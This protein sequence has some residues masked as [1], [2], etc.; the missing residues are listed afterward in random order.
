[1]FTNNSIITYFLSHR[2]YICS[3]KSLMVF[4]LMASVMFVPQN[5]A[6]AKKLRLSDDELSK[7]AVMPVF[8]EKI[9][10]KNRRVIHKNKVEIGLFGGNVL[11]EAIFDPLTFGASL[12]YHFDNTHGVFVTVGL[13]QDK[14][15]ANGERLKN[16]DV[17]DTGGNTGRFFDAS[18]AP[19]KEFMIAGHYQY[20]AYYGKFSLSK[21]TVMNLS[22]YGLLGGG[23]YMMEGLV[24]PMINLGVGQR[25]YFTKNIA[26]RLDLLLSSFYGPDITSTF[27]TANDLNEP[28]QPALPE[29]DADAFAKK[30][31]FDTQINLGITFLL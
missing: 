14:L 16:G 26:F 12:A 28:P 25:F 9:V 23:A 15:S 13:Y 29:V 10:I 18:R 4:L 22:L 24:A 11:S 8:D 3:L 21:E 20:T 27:G 19:Q 17:I 2:N 5:K 7:E 31:L 6:E 1:M 30:L